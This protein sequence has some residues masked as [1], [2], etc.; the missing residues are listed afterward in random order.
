VAK[1]P[2]IVLSAPVNVLAALA[3]SP[4]G[5][6]PTG[7]SLVL[8]VGA[9]ETPVLYEFDVNGFARPASGRQAIDAAELEL[10]DRYNAERGLM[11]QQD[12]AALDEFIRDL[13]GDTFRPHQLDWTCNRAY[14][15]SRSQS[16]RDPLALDL[17]AD[18]IE[19]IGI[20]AAGSPVLFDHDA[21]GVLTGTGW[22]AADDGWLVRDLDGNGTIDSGRELFGVDTRIVAT[23]RI[24]GTNQYITHERHAFDGFEA[25]RALDTG[26]SGAGSDGFADGVIDSRDA[27]FTDLR[28]W[29]DVNQDGASQPG[30]LMS[31]P[32]AGVA[33]ISLAS[34]ATH[35]N[36]GNGNFVTATAAV[37]R[38][39]GGV[40]QIAG[41][42]LAAGNLD[43]ADNPF[44]R[45]FT[46]TVPLTE[47]A[48]ALPEMGGSGWVR[49][50]RE[51]MS[52]GAGAELTA[53]VQQFAAAT[54][55]SAQ[56]AV[57]DGLLAAWARSSGRLAVSEYGMDLVYS[58]VVGSTETTQTLRYTASDVP[59]GP[60]PQ[61][62]Y[63]LYQFP[64]RPEFTDLV[65][66]PVG[67]Y[68]VINELGL[69]WLER[70]NVLEVFNGQRF[71]AFDETIQLQGGSG[72]GSGGGGGGQA[73]QGPVVM[74]QYR[75]ENIQID[76]IEQAYA[77]LSDSV[78]AAL[79]LQT[80]LA[81]YL[82]GIEIAIGENGVAF[83]LA[84]MLSLLQSAFAADAQVALEDLLELQRFAPG[85][86]AAVGFDA[87][88]TA[89]GWVEALPPGS[90]VLQA[91]HDAG[92]L[93]IGATLTA[94]TGPDTYLGDASANV[95][96]SGAGNDALD[97]GGGD[98]ELR[99]EAGDD[100][101]FGRAGND[102][103]FGGPGNDWL[104]GGSGDDTL[105]GG[106]GDD[107]FAFAR[108]GGRD[109][110]ANVLDAR[111]DK[112]GVLRLAPGITPAE[113]AV[114]QAQSSYWAWRA[115]LELSIAGSS[116]AITVGGLWRA[117]GGFGDEYTAVQTV[118]FADGTVWDYAALRSLVLG[119]TALADVVGGTPGHDTI[120]G[121]GGD[122]A[123]DGGSGDDTLAGG[124][125]NDTL[126]GGAGHDSFDGGPGDDILD[127]GT[128][129]DSYLF[130]RGDGQDVI[131]Q[132]A[133]GTPARSAVLVFDATV[134]PGELTLSRVH[135]DYWGSNTTLR[136]TVAGGS[137]RIDIEGFLR[138]GNP[139]D[140][141]NPVQAIRFADGTVWG[142][143]DIVTRLGLG[144]A[145]NDVIDGTS[146]DDLINGAAGNDTLRGAGGHDV[147]I[148]GPGNDTLLG[149]AGNDTLDGGT[150]NDSLDGGSGNNVYLFRRGDGQDMVPNIHDPTPGKNNVLRLG[151]DVLPQDIV[152][153]PVY[154]AYWGWNA[155]LEVGI[156]GGTDR[157]T[158][159]ALWR[160]ATGG[161]ADYAVL[162][163]I[164]FADGTVWDLPAIK[165]RAFSGTPAADT[166]T[167]TTQADTIRGAAGNDTITGGTGDDTLAGDD[168]DDTLAGDA[169]N[170]TL[171]GG[172]G[173]D[174]LRGGADADTLRGGPGN[175]LLD[176][177]SGNNTYRFGRG[178]GQDT[179]LGTLNDT[180]AG[181]LNTLLFDDGVA[182]TDLVLRQVYDAFWG[183][184]SALEVSIAGTAD[185]LTI[186]SVF[187][188]WNPGNSYNPVQQFRFADGTTWS[189]EAIK[190]RLFAGTAGADTIYGTHATDSIGAGDGNDVLYGRDGDDT[191]GGGAGNDT[192]HGESGHDS[193]AGDAGD[194][195][196]NGAAGNDTLDG[197]AGNDTLDGG[198]GNNIYLFARGGGQDRVA[199]FHDP[200]AGKA[201]VLRLTADILPADVVVRSVYSAYWGWDAD[202]ELSI[203]GSSDRITVGALWRS[204]VN[205][206]NAYSTVH[207]VEFADGTVWQFA[208]LA[209]RRLPAAGAQEPGVTLLDTGSTIGGEP[210]PMFAADLVGVSDTFSPTAFG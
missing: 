14:R 120:L 30:E 169:G 101:L 208:D 133:I 53:A 22:L 6:V 111:A 99:G 112:A 176:G 138:G 181:K 117:A 182:P 27:A 55:R 145:G 116:D 142:I 154:S 136:I 164:E 118:V 74:W 97:G 65:Q 41:V 35:T 57:V 33:S 135:S 86:L 166:I 148:G 75:V 72:G 109:Q 104:D 54:S 177:G 159:A 70:R 9:A 36:L 172:A 175:D 199:D 103:L 147:V 185:K 201:S 128:G 80:R 115:D 137:D 206:A 180:T 163:R 51:A 100:Q 205:G 67:P 59:E 124:S 209:Q 2:K 121:L 183:Y 191:I 91:L 193:L 66:G 3:G 132:A 189:L 18:G 153:R 150:G 162:Q 130:R 197:G 82:N 134:T 173:N 146:G 94:T 39:G 28:V 69:G 168:G 108:G 15:G 58:T 110:V 62:N 87:L 200:A 113:V 49:D 78:Y 85:T 141:V 19:T 25:L 46:D 88:A 81:R 4:A 194:D 171:D 96:W 40:G 43:L 60:H 98:D 92:L 144:T 157:I 119:G 95:A 192:L 79:A 186:G 158:V 204:C 190:A 114:R 45:E 187:G 73:A 68:R 10:I 89:R 26:A 152:L 143:A 20:P 37:G 160:S 105:D 23:D 174:T 38:S 93:A 207:R 29:R 149:Q 155:D 34:T 24:F 151:P 106:G 84:P 11:L 139:Y 31:L 8:H 90:P 126:V 56:K 71:F 7:L 167:G 42:G 21:D 156:A 61:P 44:Y 16:T 196:L 198:T 179:L 77:A 123:L 83:D 32:A 5:P 63:V 122:D 188:G 107:V 210:R 178:D 129:N 47:V 140:S 48:L 1:F 203:A 102:Q 12:R 184:A 125:G 52:L 64:M 161:S 170:D 76:L 17:D 165:A 50:L 131:R 202:L 13:I 195:T 127:G